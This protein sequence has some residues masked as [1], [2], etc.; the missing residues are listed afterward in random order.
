MSKAKILIVEDQADIRRL[1]R[2]SLEDT[3]HSLYEAPNGGLALD[4][5]RTLH[6]DLIFLDVMMPG[7]LDG[8]E[9]CRQLRA[10]PAFEATLI[11]MLTAD[12]AQSSKSRAL[13]AGANV[14]L[15]KPFSPARLLELTELLLNARSAAKPTP[16]HEGP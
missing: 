9:V 2:W 4:L 7:G 12:A 1:I 10:D 15:P 6:P 3:G 5:A 13:A 8:I 16:G 14:F 11:V